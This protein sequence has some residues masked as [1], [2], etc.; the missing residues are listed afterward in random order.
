MLYEGQAHEFQYAARVPPPPHNAC[1]PKAATMATDPADGKCMENP[2]LGQE[3]LPQFLKIR[4][5]HVEPAVREL[6][7][8]NRARIEELSTVPQ[9][10]FASV[11]EPLEELQHRISRTWSP[12]SHLNAVLNSDALRAGYNACLPLLIRLPDRSGAE[13]AAVSRLSHRGR[14]GGRSAC[15]RAAPAA[16]TSGA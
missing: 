15:A 7:S 9:P 5:E 1:V 14:A 6:L 8:E 4:P 10:T 3:P 16:G 2:L 11:V 13:R 12:V